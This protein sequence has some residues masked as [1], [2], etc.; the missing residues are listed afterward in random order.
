[1]FFEI[2]EENVNNIT[3]INH[4][5]VG[6]LTFE[7]VKAA[8]ANSMNEVEAIKKAEATIALLVNKGIV[9]IYNVSEDELLNDEDD[10][11]VF[12]EMTDDSADDDNS[13]PDT[14]HVEKRPRIVISDSPMENPEIPIALLSTKE[15]DLDDDMIV[16][17][18]HP[19]TEDIDDNMKIILANK[20]DTENM[21]DATKEEQDSVDGYIKSISVN[22]GPT[23]LAQTEKFTENSTME[24]LLNKYDKSG[25]YTDEYLKKHVNEK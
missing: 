7:L 14:R 5:T 23:N 19:D 6:T 9:T 24:D 1:M 21:R 4:K 22:T 20:S 13:S 17:F 16:K 12:T 18:V 11:E 2:S 3:N 25:V 10:E 8:L 15:H